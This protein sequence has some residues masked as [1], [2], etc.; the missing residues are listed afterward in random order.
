MF[1]DTHFHFH[2]MVNGCGFSGCDELIKMAKNNVFF[3]MD[4]G[5][6]SNDITERQECVLDSIEEITDPELKKKAENFIYFSAGIWPSPEEIKNRTE[7]VKILEQNVKSAFASSNPLFKKIVAIGECGLDHHWNPSGVDG[8]SLSDFD[9]EMLEGEKEMFVAQLK[10]AE[11]FQLP[12]IVHS[13][14]AFEETLECIDK[15]GYHNGII[16]CYSYDKNA[17]EQFLQRGWYIALGGGMTY[18]KKSKMEEIKEL[19]NS[20][21]ENRLLLETDAPYLS[22]V[23]LRGTQNTPNNI[24][25]TYEFIADVR[26]VSV[27]YLCSVVDEN[28]RT[29]FKLADG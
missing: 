28:S 27:E 20:I 8:R 26:G 23:P 19:I 9:K 11:K 17:A 24:N 1:S 3:A 16:H 5:T 15:A 29:L 18:T 13:R 12:V 10:L 22:P 6:K 4:I 2:Q 25:Y 7:S 14:D 21:P